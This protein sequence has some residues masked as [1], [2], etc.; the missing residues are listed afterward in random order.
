MEEL[1][2][3]LLQC[4]GITGMPDH[5]FELGTGDKWQTPTV[6]DSE[7]KGMSPSKFSQYAHRLQ[8]NPCF[9]YQNTSF[10]G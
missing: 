2:T 5:I 9:E 7:G 4:V 8:E 1:L 3:G 10:L 6:C